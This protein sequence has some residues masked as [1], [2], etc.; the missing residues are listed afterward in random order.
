MSLP[1]LAACTGVLVAAVATGILVGRCVRRPRPCYLAWTAAASGLT[2][3]MGPAAVRLASGSGP[4][5]FRAVQPDLGSELDRTRAR[6]RPDWR[7]PRRS[8]GGEP[9]LVVA[10]PCRVSAASSIGGRAGRVRRDEVS[11]SR[12]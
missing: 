11:E 8:G 6:R 12:E 7:C 2:A 3:T 10:G 9:A 4:S 1:V 5:A